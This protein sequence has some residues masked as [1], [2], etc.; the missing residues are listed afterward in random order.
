[1]RILLVG[2]PR[3]SRKNVQKT[4]EFMVFQRRLQDLRQ[5]KSLKAD[6]KL[7]RD[8]LACGVTVRLLKE[9]EGFLKVTVFPRIRAAVIW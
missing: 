9:V 5:Q 2:W 4:V 3:K 8:F 1:M 6:H 7:I